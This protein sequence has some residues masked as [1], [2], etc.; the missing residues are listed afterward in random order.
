MKDCDAMYMIEGNQLCKYPNFYCPYH[1]KK[2]IME[3][4]KARDVVTLCDVNKLE[5]LLLD[6]IFPQ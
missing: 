1:G 6:K 5:Y 2:V 4:M 3:F